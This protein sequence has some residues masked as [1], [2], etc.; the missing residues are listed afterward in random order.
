MRNKVQGAPG[1][2]VPKGQAVGGRWRVVACLLPS[3][4]PTKPGSV[5]RSQVGA[6]PGLFIVSMHQGRPPCHPTHPPPKR[7]HRCATARP[8][9]PHHVLRYCLPAGPVEMYE[10]GPGQQIKAMVR[11][12]DA[13]AWKAFRNVQP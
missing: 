2:G 10:L 7:M 1:G 3:E 8:A 11:R 12:M 9:A 13:V 4:V 6:A 5:K